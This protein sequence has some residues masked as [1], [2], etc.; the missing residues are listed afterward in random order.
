MAHLLKVTHQ[1]SQAGFFDEIHHR[2]GG[3]GSRNCW[4]SLAFK[5]ARFFAGAHMQ[6]PVHPRGSYAK[7]L[8]FLTARMYFHSTG[9]WFMKV[10]SSRLKSLD[11]KLVFPVYL[12]KTRKG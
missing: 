10:L 12:E 1:Q 4:R 6:L 8:P 5:S 9:K 2:I 3:Q 7:W 11:P